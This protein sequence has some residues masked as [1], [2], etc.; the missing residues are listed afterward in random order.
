MKRNIHIQG[1]A[2]VSLLVSSLSAEP[3]A[4][5]LIKPAAVVPGRTAEIVLEGTHLTEPLQLWT[6]FTCRCEFAPAANEREQKGEQ[7]TCQ[8]TLPRDEQVGIGVI[9]LVTAGGQSPAR[10]VLVD[11][12]ASILETGNNHELAGAQDLIT[13]CAVE[14]MCDATEEDFFRF[15]ARAGETLSF[16]V[17]SAR[18]GLKLDPVLRLFDTSGV[19]LTRVDD[20]TEVGGDSRFQHTFDS[21]GQYTLGIRDVSHGGGPEYRY[22]LRIGRFPLINV[23]Y[24]AGGQAGTL[25]TIQALGHMNGAIRVQHLEMPDCQQSCLTS[26]GVRGPGDDA[27]GW[28]VAE[29]GQFPEHLEQ[30]PNQDIVQASQLTLPG[31]V[32]GRIDSDGDFDHFQFKARQGERLACQAM[33]RVIGSAC[34]VF[35]SLHRPDGSRLVQAAQGREV[36][37]RYVIPDDGEYILRVE[38]LIQGGGPQHIYRVAMT[39]ADPGFSLKTENPQLSAPQEGTFATKVTVARHGYDGPIDLEVTGLGDGITLGGHQIKEGETSLQVTLPTGLTKGDFRLATIVGRATNNEQPVSV[40]LD[41]FD[42]PGVVGLFPNAVSL[43]TTLREQLAIWISGPVGPFFELSVPGPAYFPRTVGKSSFAIDVKRLDEAFKDAVQ[44]TVEGVPEGI[45]VEVQ[46]VEE[47]LTQYQV[48][49]TGPP[50]LE[51]ATVPLRIVGTATH[52]LQKKSVT[53][54]NIEL[55][56]TD[57]LV[58]TVEPQGPLVAGGT[59][60]AIIRV[61]RFGENPSPVEVRFRNAPAGLLAP[62]VTS[63][64]SDADQAEIVLAADASAPPGTYDNLVAVA[65]TMLADQALTAPSAPAT[66]EIQAAPTEA[67]AAEPAAATEPVATAEPAATAE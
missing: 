44:I 43:P 47:G 1:L 7:L 62:I 31:V 29:V 58:V 35:M 9:R 63:I 36:V 54:E 21:Y 51:P 30:E 60:K 41:N 66:I 55:K 33:T 6:S 12:L 13:P 59:Q 16:E 10:M 49:L 42:L 40:P 8:V 27:S 2:V 50:D 32:N 46:P 18:L 14:G 25:A 5:T 53:L 17:V 3:P 64:P 39:N 67:A 23:A 15:R 45:T 28:F 57:P 38:N 4:I 37:L 22:R 19:E 11:D 26:F 34:D 52:N 24:P 20:A 65:N 61:V 56:I 48:V